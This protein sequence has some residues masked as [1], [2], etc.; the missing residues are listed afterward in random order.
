MKHLLFGSSNNTLIQFFRYF[1]VGG[2]SA[3]VDLAIFSTLVYLVDAHW[4]LA[5][6]AGYSIGIVWNYVVSIIWI[7]KSKNIKKE[8][9]LVFSIGMGGLLLTWALLYVFIDLWLWNN[10]LAKMASQ[11]LILVWNFGLRKWLVF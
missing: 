3:I 4:L 7:F 8:L 9:L 10:I 5:A 11:I 6:I 2:S 1:W